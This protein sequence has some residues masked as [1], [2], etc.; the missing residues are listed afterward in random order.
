M[1]GMPSS[2][3]EK[4]GIMFQAYYDCLADVPLPKTEYYPIG[5]KRHEVKKF[6]QNVTCGAFFPLSFCQKLLILYQNSK[7]LRNKDF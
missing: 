1:K 7:I 2:C 6:L 5:A 4:N 3:F